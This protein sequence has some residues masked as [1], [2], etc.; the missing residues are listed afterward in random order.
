MIEKD[1]YWQMYADVWNN[2]HKKF[3]DKIDGTDAFWQEVRDIARSVFIVGE[4]AEHKRYLSNEKNN[5]AETGETAIFTIE[6]G[7]AVFDSY[8]NKKDQDFVRERDYNS[9][10]APQRQ[11][12][13]KFILDF[14]KNGKKPTKDLDEAASAAG[15]S[16]GTLKRAKTKLR[17]QKLLGIKSEGYGNTKIFYSYLLDNRSIP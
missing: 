4:T 8:S 16:I 11:D 9:Y 2:L 1:K 7:V 15:I 14:L 3:I 13:E 10:Q 6:D 5:Y 12:A 17:E